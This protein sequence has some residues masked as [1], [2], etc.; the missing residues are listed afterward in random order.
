MAKDKQW[1]QDAVK[2]PGQL[3]RDLNVPAGQP[4]PASKLAKAARRDDAVG[5]RARLALV[6]RK[7]SRSKD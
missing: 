5:Q 2:R 7:L 1:I 6:L 3:R 4:I